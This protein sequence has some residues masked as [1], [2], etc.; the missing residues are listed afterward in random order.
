MAKAQGLVK[1]ALK[2]SNNP[3]F[4]SSYADLSSVIDAIREAFSTNGLSYT[5]PVSFIGD[6]WFI[7][8]MIMH[9]SGQWIQSD[10]VKIP[11]KD[12]TNP[13]SFG[14]STTYLRR[15]CLASMVGVA[16]VDDDAEAAI[17]PQGAQTYPQP[18]SAK[19]VVNNYAPNMQGQTKPQPPPIKDGMT[20][21]QDQPR[22][23]PVLNK[24]KETKG[25]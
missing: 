17:R 5:Q 6:S 16:Q 7:E 10:A 21:K 1:G 19:P 8:T 18:P 9:S 22:V 13:Q 11:I 24:L 4:K 25:I 15:Y 20:L 23:S 14:S 3:F 12:V 2:D